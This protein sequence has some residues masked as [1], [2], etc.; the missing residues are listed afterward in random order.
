MVITAAGTA[1]IVGATITAG[2]KGVNE[3]AT[4]S[5]AA[6]AADEVENQG[7]YNEPAVLISARAGSLIA[8]IPRRLATLIER[9]SNSGGSFQRSGSGP[10]AK[11]IKSPLSF[12]S[13]VTTPRGPDAGPCSH[14]I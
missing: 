3:V 14:P 8:S 1:D 9:G 2:T 10:G 5:A 13:G 12:E 6:E 7:D 4:D 11:Y